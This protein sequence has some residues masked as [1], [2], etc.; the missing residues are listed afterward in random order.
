M[1][2]LLATDFAAPFMKKITSTLIHLRAHTSWLDDS[3]APSIL[4]LN[5]YWRTVVQMWLDGW[6]PDLLLPHAE[7]AFFVLMGWCTFAIVYWGLNALLGIVYHFDLFPQWKIQP[8][9]K[10][11]SRALIL[12]CIRHNLIDH[13]VSQPLVVTLLVYP[14]S[15][16][17]FLKIC[18]VYQPC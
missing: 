10:W 6:C 18:R 13:N 1:R 5:G 16:D 2:A 3:A 15:K 7:C 14:L 8:A 17:A 9:N 12:D 4:W 11:P